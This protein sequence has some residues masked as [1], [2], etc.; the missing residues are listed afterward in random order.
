[1][2]AWLAALSNWFR[3][4]LQESTKD[5]LQRLYRD[6]TVWSYSEARTYMYNEVDCQSNQIRL[7]YGGNFYDW[8]CGGS[9]KPSGS[10]VNA[11]HVVPQ[12]LFQS[13]T[14]MVSDLHHLM[15]SPA[16]LNSMRANYKFDEVDYSDCTQFCRDYACSTQTPSDPDEYSCLSTAKTWMPRVADR[17]EIAR[18][19]LYFFTMY[20]DYD[21]TTV[22]T[23]R[24]FKKW[25][26]LYPPSAYEKGRN[27]RI[28]QTMGNRN[29]YID[30]P[31]LVDQVF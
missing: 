8:T 30:D 1:M 19:I 27:E 22:G 6:H 3:P 23:V 14:P 2:L 4:E 13:E 16:K 25:N 12:S 28:N 15:S 10:I 5:R 26:S 9:N 31:T 29:P 24:V 20:D 17:G 11:E 7:I 18:A 21:I